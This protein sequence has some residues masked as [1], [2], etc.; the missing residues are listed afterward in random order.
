MVLHMGGG[1]MIIQMF[2]ALPLF[3]KN[4][5]PFFKDVRVEFIP[6]TSWLCTDKGNNPFNLKS[7]ILAMI[8]MNPTPGCNK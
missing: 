3:T 6:G 4:E 2:L 8:D 1:D 5:Q 7:K